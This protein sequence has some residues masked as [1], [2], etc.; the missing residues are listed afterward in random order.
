MLMTPISPRVRQRLPGQGAPRAW[1]VDLELAAPGIDPEELL[2]ACDGFLVDDARGR[3]IGVVEGVETDEAGVATALVIAVG[4]F[5]RRT[6]RVPVD[7]VDSLLPRE[8]R[9]VLRDSYA[10]SRTVSRSR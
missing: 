9:V 3:Q 4:W 5:G 7:A 2:A 8:R 6:L 10:R 1:F